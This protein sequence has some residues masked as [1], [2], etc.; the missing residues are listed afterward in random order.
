MGYFLKE[1]M[2]L[3][4]SESLGKL[5]TACQDLVSV[6]RLKEYHTSGFCFGIKEFDNDVRKYN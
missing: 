6:F 3:H 1:I 4:N 5:Q 2:F